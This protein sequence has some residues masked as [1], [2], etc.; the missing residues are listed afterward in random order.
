MMMTEAN[1][2]T[3][4]RLM[5]DLLA[6][7]DP[8][9]TAR[10]LA[11]FGE[12]AVRAA[13]DPAPWGPIPKDRNSRDLSDDLTQVLQF[14]AARD[15][16]I[17]IDALAAGGDRAWKL[18]FALASSRESAAV[19]ALVSAASVRSAAIRRLGV[20]GLGATGDPRAVP[21]LL[22]ALQDKD[23]SVRMAA[24]EALARFHH[25]PLMRDAI[26]R[27]LA[28][29]GLGPG[30]EVYGGRIAATLAGPE[31]F[32]AIARASR[33]DLALAGEA[34]CAAHAPRVRA[35]ADRIGRL[36]DRFVVWWSRATPPD[37]LR[38]RQMG[39]ALAAPLDPVHF[40]IV[41]EMGCVRIAGPDGGPDWTFPG[42]VEGGAPWTD[43][44]ELS[45]SRVPEGA[46]LVPLAFRAGDP[47]T[48]GYRPDG[49]VV[50]WRPGGAPEST[51]FPNVA[52]FFERTVEELD[53]LSR[54]RARSR[55]V[56]KVDRLKTP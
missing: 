11:T 18:L 28:R 27:L 53:A 16:R 40:A 17:L 8:I 54:E 35:L 1:Q 33:R 7:R 6:G 10:R 12:A 19:E 23:A 14:V 34:S 20:S 2:Q 21:P 39:E 26:D 3:L 47:E 51:E 36:G 5:H 37:P 52:G 41:V 44:A 38:V 25:P 56:R 13:L 45:R 43:L 42:L 29:P 22:R 46:N 49:Q 48:L 31:G 55:P 32:D 15:A 50:R 9:G 4:D 24:V 30:E